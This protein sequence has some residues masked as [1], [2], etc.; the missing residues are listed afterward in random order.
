MLFLQ[1]HAPYT[2]AML[3]SLLGVITRKQGGWVAVEVG[4]IGYKVVCPLSVLSQLPALGDQVKL[5][6]HHHVR[7]DADDLY[8][9]LQD[10]ELSLFESLISINGVGPKSAMGIMGVAPTA[11]IIAAINEGRTDL[12]SKASGVGKKTAERVIL[13]LKGKLTFADT[14]GAITKMEGDMELEE[15]LVSLGY[16]KQQAKGAISKLDPKLKDFNERLKAVLKEYKK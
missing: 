8:G 7:E 5:L 12:L 16:S 9:F 2:K 13:E 4:G 3:Y 10:Q 1:G 11:E 14:S 15:T 6:I